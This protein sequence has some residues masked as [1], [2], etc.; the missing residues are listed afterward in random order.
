MEISNISLK[1]YVPL[2]EYILSDANVR[3]AA[4]FDDE[5][6][7]V[8]IVEDGLGEGGDVYA[9]RAWAIVQDTLKEIE[10]K[11]GL[12]TKQY[13]NPSILEILSTKF[14]VDYENY[15]YFALCKYEQECRVISPAGV[16][17]H[18]DRF[19]G[20]GVFFYSDVAGAFVLWDDAPGWE[21][22]E[23]FSYEIFEMLNHRQPLAKYLDYCIK[24][25]EGETSISI[26]NNENVYIPLGY[27][28]LSD[29]SYDE[30]LIIG[31]LV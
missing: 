27:V 8:S 23:G 2:K 24:N 17:T 14:S 20:E 3:Y 30:Y 29:P 4:K 5:K 11:R 16:H 1:Y 12:Y 21:T 15:S 31:K 19:V 9:P 28:N 6:K 7:A 18:Q 25:Y 10:K 26:Y 22:I 13:K